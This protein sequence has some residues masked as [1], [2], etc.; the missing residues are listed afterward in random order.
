MHKIN[1]ILTQCQVLN[2]YNFLENVLENV[3][4]AIDHFNFEFEHALQYIMHF[5]ISYF[6]QNAFSSKAYF[7]VHP[8]WLSENVDPPRSQPLPRKP[9]PWEQPKYRQNVQRYENGQMTPDTSTPSQTTPLPEFSDPEPGYSYTQP[10]R[11]DYESEILERKPQ[12][13]LSVNR[14]F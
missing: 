9:W 7:I 12:M 13:D 2:D 1:L 10:L 8:E 5:S 3:K 11:N 6:M 14:L 4:I